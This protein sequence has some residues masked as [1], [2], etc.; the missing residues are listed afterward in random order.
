MCLGFLSDLLWGGSKAG[1]EGVKE[2]FKDKKFY[3]EC[4]YSGSGFGEIFQGVDPGLGKN[5]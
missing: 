3:S 4:C 2:S 1:Q 5:R